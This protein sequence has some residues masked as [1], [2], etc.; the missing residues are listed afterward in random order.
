MVITNRDKSDLVKKEQ[1][2]F[3]KNVDTL[4]HSEAKTKRL[5]GVL[6]L[7][8]RLYYDWTLETDIIQ[9]RGPIQYLIGSKSNTVTGDMF[10]KSLTFDDF[11]KRI[12]LLSTSFETRNSFSIDYHLPMG[13]ELFCLVQENAELLFTK[14]GVP[15][16]MLGSIQV[17]PQALT[18][19]SKPTLAKDEQTGVFSS[20]EI[21]KMLSASILRSQREK[22]YGAFVA[23]SIDKLTKIA[24]LA[25]EQGVDKVINF[26]S[27]SLKENIR[28]KDQIGRL[29]GNTFGLVLYNCDRWGIV[30]ASERLIDALH[31][32][33][34][35]LGRGQS[36]QLSVSS[37]GAVFPCETLSAPEIIR[38]ANLA[39]MD[40]QQTRGISRYWG[41]SIIKGG[42][43]R[44]PLKKAAPKGKRRMID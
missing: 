9:W 36:P 40:A 29:N 35:D 30:A 3:K 37:G 1:K 14:E 6:T 34:L 24:A 13:D 12:S 7:Y 20:T 2:A 5:I 27:K 38:E 8:G 22:N 43:D 41:P 21:E 33:P 16:K 19:K 26:V 10:L 4:L 23:L 17:L 44:P 28:D 32:T 15:A 11:Q 31:R 25:G 18:L 39:L 42:S